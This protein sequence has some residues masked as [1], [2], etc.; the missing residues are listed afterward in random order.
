MDRWLEFSDMEVLFGDKKRI[1]FGSLSLEEDYALIYGKSGSGKTTLIHAL[2]GIIPNVRPGKV[3]GKIRIL[4]VFSKDGH[5]KEEFRRITRRAFLVLQEVD[6]NLFAKSVEDE[7]MLDFE[8]I[9]R[10][11]IKLLGLE[12]LLSRDIES[13]SYGEKQKVAL[14]IALSHGSEVIFMDE[15][16][17]HLDIPSRKGLKQTLD[18]VVS[19]GKKVV[20]SEHRVGYFMNCKVK[21][22]VTRDGVIYRHNIEQR[23]LKDIIK[24]TKESNTRKKGGTILRTRGLEITV[25]DFKLYDVN[26]E[27]NENEIVGIIGSNGSGKTTLAKALSGIIDHK[28]EIFIEGNRMHRKDLLGKVAYMHQNPDI[29]LFETSVWKEVMLGAK[30][31]PMPYVK[32]LG[33]ENYLGVDPH[34]LSRGER[35]RVVLAALLSSAPKIV[36]LDEPTSGQDVESTI[37]IIRAIV[38]SNKSVIIITHEIDLVRE[39]CDRVYIIKEGTTHEIDPKNVTEDIF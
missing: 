32:L 33:L 24:G 2:L 36:I 39:V 27:I 17:A 3:L 29:Q 28:G 38:E 21:V 9:P 22:E 6:H 1:Y 14:A 5:L 34:V 13:L 4:D 18:R 26:I 19:L 23:N 11:V 37:N 10:D 12:S 25:G 8:S 35:L 15:P 7:F 31:D 30:E 20:V 16:L